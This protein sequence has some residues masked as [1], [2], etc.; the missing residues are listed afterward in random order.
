VL[1]AS[2]SL[3]LVAGILWT[4]WAYQNRPHV[5]GP[6]LASALDSLREALR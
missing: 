3:A 4:T 2:S 1:L 6:E 5:L